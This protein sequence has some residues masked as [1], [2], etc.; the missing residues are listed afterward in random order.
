MVKRQIGTQSRTFNETYDAYSSFA[1]VFLGD[2]LCCCSA[3]AI[4]QKKM[5]VHIG[6]LLGQKIH[7]QFLKTQCISSQN[8]DILLI[9][10]VMQT[11]SYITRKLE[12]YL[13]IS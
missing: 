2:F 11:Q 7:N 10:F 4:S 12:N 5:M 8:I 9:N 13:F 3:V 1:S 6:I